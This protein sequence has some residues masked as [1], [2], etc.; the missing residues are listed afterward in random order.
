VLPMW[1][2]SA[3]ASTRRKPGQ[4]GPQVE[5]YRAWLT[6]RGYTPQTVRNMLADLGRAGRWMS[7]EGLAAE[8]LDEDA[9]AAFRAA[10]AAGHHRVLGP[11]AMV[12]LLSYLREAAGRGVPGLAGPGPW[13]GGGHGAAV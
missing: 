1:E 5:G 10:W 12:P 4:L 7:G 11:R 13:A 9:M 3:M 2:A 6:R 8:Q